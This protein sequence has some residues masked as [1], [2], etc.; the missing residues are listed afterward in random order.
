MIGWLARFPV[1]TPRCE[2]RGKVRFSHRS[3][4]RLETRT[5]HGF[6]PGEGGLTGTKSGTRRPLNRGGLTGS[7]AELFCNQRL[8]GAA[9]VAVFYLGSKLGSRD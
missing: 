1:G 5:K 4:Q 9:C 6:F 7:R 2:N 8:C 3:R